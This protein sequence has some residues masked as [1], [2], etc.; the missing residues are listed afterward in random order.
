M[1]FYRNSPS[2]LISQGVNPRTV[3]TI[4]GHADVSTTLNTYTS[5]YKE[6]ESKCFY[7]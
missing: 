4:L 3:Q 2:L 5:S 7:G 6:D 1:G